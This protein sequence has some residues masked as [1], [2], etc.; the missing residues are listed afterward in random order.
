[1]VLQ[2]FGTAADRFLLK[3]DC[4]IGVTLLPLG[5]PSKGFFHALSVHHDPD[6]II[7]ILADSE[8]AG[9]VFSI[10]DALVLRVDPLGHGDPP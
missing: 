6:G 5:F 3:T 7:T 10:S 1:M 4:S 9:R 8:F 2:Q